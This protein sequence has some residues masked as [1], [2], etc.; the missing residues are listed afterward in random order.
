MMIESQPEIPPE[1]SFSTTAPQWDCFALHQM[2][3]V[4][5]EA[6]SCSLGGLAFAFARSS[7]TST[8]QRAET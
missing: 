7:T 4:F 2:P 5:I 6:S 3:R 8:L 1:A